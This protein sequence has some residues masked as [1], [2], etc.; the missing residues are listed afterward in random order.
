MV[1][2]PAPHFIF[3]HG[4]GD[5]GFDASGFL[6]MDAPERVGEFLMKGVVIMARYP[7]LCKGETVQGGI[8]RL[9]LEMLGDT[10]RPACFTIFT[11]A[12][13]DEKNFFHLDRNLQFL[14]GEERDHLVLNPLRRLKRREAPMRRA[15]PD[16]FDK[17]ESTVIEM[18]RKGP[19]QQEFCLSNLSG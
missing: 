19:L 12:L 7:L 14:H 16:Q 13:G 9:I 2:H 15:E 5:T 17:R 4:S 8:G 3:C 1:G 6:T 18:V 11:T 10:G